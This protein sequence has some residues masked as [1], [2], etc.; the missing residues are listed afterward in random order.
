MTVGSSRSNDTTI[1]Y[2]NLVGAPRRHNNGNFD[3]N[4]CA[5]NNRFPDGKTLLSFWESSSSKFNNTNCLLPLLSDH[6]SPFS[7]LNTPHSFTIQQQVTIFFRIFPFERSLFCRN[8]IV[9]HTQHNTFV[10][11]IAIIKT[12]EIILSS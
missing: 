1:V 11:Y 9:N 6:F 4:T 12:L 5:P 3:R 10:V 7:L 8:K 2:K